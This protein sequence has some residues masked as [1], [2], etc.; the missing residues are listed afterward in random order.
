MYKNFESTKARNLKFGDMIRLYMK[1]CT[2]VFGAVRSHGLRK[3]PKT[4][5]VSC[6]FKKWLKVIS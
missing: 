4:C 3:G 5:D 6:Y 1:L 2:C